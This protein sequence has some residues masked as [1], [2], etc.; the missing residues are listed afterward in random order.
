[1]VKKPYISKKCAGQ[2]GTGPPCKNYEPGEDTLEEGPPDPCEEG[3]P[4]PCTTCKWYFG[5]MYEPKEI[6]EST[7]EHMNRV[8]HGEEPEAA[9]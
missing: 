6:E 9:Q 7:E 1:M 8:W 2:T 4:D 3:P 5:S